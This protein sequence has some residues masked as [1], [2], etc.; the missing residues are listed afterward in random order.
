[1]LSIDRVRS[2]LR[3]HLARV[4]LRYGI[5]G[6]SVA[7]AVGDETAEAAAGVVNL[8]TKVPATAGSVFQIQ[9]I[10]K[11][12]TA[13]LVMQL[14]DEGLVGLDD[15]VA[16]HL[17]GFRT[18]DA[19]ASARI[20]V[21]HLLTHTGGFEGD[22]W[23]ATTSGDDALQRLVEDHVP[24]LAQREAPGSRY[25]YCSAGMAVL[26]RLVEVKRG[27]PFAAA[28]RD[29]LAGPLG[30]SE[31][32]FNADEALGFNTAIGHLDTGSGKG[33][34]PVWAT[35]PESNPAAGNQLAMSARALCAFG[36]MHAAD[37][38]GPDGTR[39]LS[40]ASA[41]LMREAG[42]ALP[43]FAVPRSVGLGW[44][45]VGDGALVQHGGGAIGV[46]SVLLV[47][48]SRRVVVAVLVNDS[49]YL[50]L[51][52]DLVDPW[53]A[54]AAGVVP[55]PAPVLSGPEA[56]LAGVER[57]TGVYADRN[58]R[59][60]VAVREGRIER[61]YTPLGGARSMMVRAGL[62]PEP[63]TDEI[64]RVAGDLFATRNPD[65]TAGG[66]TQFLDVEDGRARFM[67]S[68]RRSVPRQG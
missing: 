68:G 63:F 17:P 27:L 41:A 39:L 37:G 25:S 22:L 43:A 29:H 8:R 47:V 40:P 4:L 6:A 46:Q 36:R 56:S 42:P 38:L 60:A 20:T 57:Y 33:P 48:P 24:T 2:D 13:T 35:M 58:Q 53:I 49:A 7:V 15:P 45:V 14:V 54:E 34:L 30:I 10:T 50:G 65:G 66:Y 5:A 62:P 9:S 44:E 12:W 32:A 61:T 31:I 16:D 55:D 23:E 3:D 67:H 28:T 64:R 18:A 19:A 11:V 59:I 26:G 1:M 51:M 21:R 52:R